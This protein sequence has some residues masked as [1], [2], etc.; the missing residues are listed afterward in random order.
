MGAEWLK[1]CEFVQGFQ[2][3]FV[4]PFDRN[5]ASVVLPTSEAPMNTNHRVARDQAAQ[6][7]QLPMTTKHYQSSPVRHSFSQ[8]HA[9]DYSIGGWT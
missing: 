1:G 2:S 3:L 5:S 9:R 8:Q 7:C 4:Q 6:D